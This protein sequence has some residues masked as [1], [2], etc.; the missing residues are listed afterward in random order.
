MDIDLIRRLSEARG[1]SRFEEE[2]REVIKKEVEKEADWVKTDNMGNLIAFRK[3]NGEKPKKIAF[4]SHM[5]E[6]GFIAKRMSG[7]FVEF[8]KVGG[9][10]DRILASRKVIIK[11]EKDYDGI[12]VSKPIF[13]QK[14]EDRDK[15]IKYDDM[16]IDLGLVHEKKKKKKEG[17]EEE[18]GEE[19]PK[20]KIEKGTPISFASKFTKMTDTTYCG[21]S[22]DNR[23]GV[24]CLIE[25]LK[26]LKNH[27]D[28]LYF[29]FSTQEEV[30]LKGSRTATY[31]IEPDLAI[32]LDT[33]PS[34]DLPMI[35]KKESEI[36][37]GKGP[38]IVLLE[39]DGQGTVLPDT[40]R[41]FLLE[42]AKKNKIKHQL[43][44]SEGG[45]TEAAIVQIVK[46]GILAC[47]IGIPTR[48]LHTPYEIFDTRD[49]EETLKFVELVAN[50][51]K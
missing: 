20:I 4:V 23:L 37:L 12:I 27:K 2:V 34:G 30:G 43:E 35:S 32:I 26:K 33:T 29:V 19:S 15:Q 48:N 21:K 18:N 24:Y 16:C 3:G 31:E 8:L 1:V 25:L 6:I 28:D 40:L 51:W 11:A 50:N 9:I 17:E 45:L 10:D 42:T 41:K 44:I 14:K 22:F 7:G 46:R 5:D 49:V 38:T 39:A 36:S 47:S 13:F